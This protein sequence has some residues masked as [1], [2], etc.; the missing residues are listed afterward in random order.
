[1]NNTIFLF[2]ASL[3]L[4]TAVNAQSTVDSIRA[5]YQL[6]PM[7]EALTIE[8]TF[9]V[10][11]SYQL[12]AEDGSAQTVTVTLDSVN[13]GIVWVEGLPEG[14]F[15]AFL[16]QSPGIYRVIAQKSASGRQ[17]PEGTLYFDPATSTLSIA[18]GKHFDNVDP[19]AVFNAA[20]ANTEVAE[21]KVKTK[22]GKS[23]TKVVFYN[24]IKE[25]QSTTVS[26]SFEEQLNKQ[27]QQ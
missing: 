21:V 18:L 3:F 11:G 24:A 27:Q 1:M 6:L 9:P 20:G 16:R 26:N 13:K 2:I 25:Q 10:L 5:K 15:K 19:V 7:P 23:K 4:A 22:K 17:I 12:T 8:K 14:K